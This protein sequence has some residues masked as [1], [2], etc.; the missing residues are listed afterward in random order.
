MT[1]INRIKKH[2]EENKMQTEEED[3]YGDAS[4][5]DV[6]QDMMLLRKHEKKSIIK[7]INKE[8]NSPKNMIPFE[9]LAIGPGRW[10]NGLFIKTTHKVGEMIFINGPIIQTKYQDLT[11]IF[12]KERDVV[13]KLK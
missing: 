8:T 3:V 7:L 10:E 1:Q 2:M 4:I 9:I 12:G 5:M 13:A 11:F 6:D